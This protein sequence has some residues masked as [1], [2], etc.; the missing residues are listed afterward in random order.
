MVYIRKKHVY[1]GFSY[2]PQFWA[3]AVV[4]EIYPPQTKGGSTDMDLVF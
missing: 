2:Y 4:V 3:S 1:T